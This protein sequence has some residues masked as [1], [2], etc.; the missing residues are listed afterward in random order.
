MKLLNNPDADNPAIISRFHR[1]G[2]SPCSRSLHVAT[3]YRVGQDE[4]G[5]MFIAMERLRMTRR[6]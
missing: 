5:V 4:R 6:S 2:R 3:V 1:E